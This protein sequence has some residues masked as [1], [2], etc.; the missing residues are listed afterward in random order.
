MVAE[1]GV[2]G[3]RHDDPSRLRADHSVISNCLRSIVQ[4]WFA[5]EYLRCI[6]ESRLQFLARRE[7]KQFSSY[8]VSEVV[9][10]S[11]EALLVGNDV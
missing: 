3:G 5:L 11:L 9:G 2:V 10:W 8:R 4:A 6:R 1:A 7:N